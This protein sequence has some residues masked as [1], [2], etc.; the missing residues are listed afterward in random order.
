M[1]TL[2]INHFAL[3]RFLLLLILMCASVGVFAQPKNRDAALAY[4]KALS[5][6]NA[7]NYQFAIPYLT[8]AVTYD[9]SFEAAY[10]L[11]AISFDQT[12]DTRNAILNYEKVLQLNPNQEKVWYN[13]SFLYVDNK[14]SNKAIQALEKAIKIAPDYA[15]AHQ[16]LGVLYAQ[17][18][19]GSKAGEHY[20]EA[21][22]GGMKIPA[23]SEATAYFKK[24][25]YQNALKKAEEAIQATD[26][27][28]AHYMKGLALTRLERVDEAIQAFS[29]ATQKQA[30]YTSAWVELGILQY[31]QEQFKAAATT[32]GKAVSL[33]P[34]DAELNAF[35]GS[36][37]VSSEQYSKAVGPLKKGIAD[38][39]DNAELNYYLAEAL[40]NGGKD[41]EA[42]Q[43]YAKAESLGFKGKKGSGGLRWIPG[44]RRH[45]AGGSYRP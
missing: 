35:Y 26:D 32:F 25:D 4:N 21:S 42:D 31:N 5:H 27:A 7:Q 23:L 38:D 2:L 28:E 39:P 13:L 18:G 37:L 17:A 19:D 41:A 11:L 3:P 20:D 14:Q 43:L 36:A 22:K 6:Y 8:E 34:E 29:N 44:L 33:K 45:H 24:R 10:H 9:P 12:K 16:R 1:N 40:K 15:K 30:D